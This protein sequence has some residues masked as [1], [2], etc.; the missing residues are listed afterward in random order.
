MAWSLKPYD[1]LDITYFY[2]WRIL[3]AKVKP[4]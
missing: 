2:V 3:D 4:K 1:L